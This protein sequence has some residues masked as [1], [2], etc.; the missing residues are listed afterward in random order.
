MAPLQIS[1]IDLLAEAMLVIRTAGRAGEA[2]RCWRVAEGCH[3]VHL[4]LRGLGLRGQCDVDRLLEVDLLPMAEAVPELRMA[5]SRV[6]VAW[7]QE[8]S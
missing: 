3:N 8:R 5:V 4:G 2:S 6:R 7:N 1:M